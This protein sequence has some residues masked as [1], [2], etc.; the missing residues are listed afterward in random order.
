MPTVGQLNDFY[1]DFPYPI[2]KRLAQSAWNPAVFLRL[3]QQDRTDA[4]ILQ[5]AQ[6]LMVHVGIKKRYSTT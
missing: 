1:I 2:P 5:V 4:E 3:R 6:Q